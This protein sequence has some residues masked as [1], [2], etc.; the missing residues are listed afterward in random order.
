MR[1]FKPANTLVFFHCCVEARS[2]VPSASQ[3]SSVYTTHPHTLKHKYTLP[4]LPHTG[5]VGRYGASAAPCTNKPSLP[6]TY[7]WKQTTGRWNGMEHP[8]IYWIISISSIV[9]SVDYRQQ[10]LLAW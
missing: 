8:V 6:C 10:S 5:L 7:V 4:S 9:V 2:A 1:G 3:T